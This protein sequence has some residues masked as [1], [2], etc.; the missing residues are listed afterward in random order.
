MLLFWN[1]KLETGSEGE[2]FSDGKVLIKHIIL[3][4]VG[5]ITSEG[6]L[7]ARHL[8]VEEQS[9][10][11]V[12]VVSQGATVTQDVKEGG[13]TCTGGTHNVQRLT[14]HGIAV[15]ILNDL[16]SLHLGAE[17]GLLLRSSKNGNLKLNVSPGELDGS[18]ASLES[19][20]DLLFSLLVRA[21]RHRES[22][23]WKTNVGDTFR[24]VGLHVGTLLLKNA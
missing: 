21:S 22:S 3:H 16:Q 17:F 18:L 12:S 5:S 1:L 19:I 20:L 9:T 13:L 8:V 7:V 6:L 10:T 14:W 2:C 24:V 4:D 23:I 11:E 15:S